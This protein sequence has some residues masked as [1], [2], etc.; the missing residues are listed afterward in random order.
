MDHAPAGCGYRDLV[1][2]AWVVETWPGAGSSDLREARHQAQ[3]PTCGWAGSVRRTAA[4]AEK[5]GRRH[6]DA[7]A[8]V[9]R[10][11]LGR[12]PAAAQ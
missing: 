12:D 6:A 1:N 8:D 7:A 4:L 3:C 2:H 9:L 11:V 10:N 5:D